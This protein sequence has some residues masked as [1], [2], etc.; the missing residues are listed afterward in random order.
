[1]CALLVQVKNNSRLRSLSR[2]ATWHRSGRCAAIITTTTTIN[3]TNFQDWIATKVIGA[4]S[5]RRCGKYSHCFC[6]RSCCLHFALKTNRKIMLFEASS[7]EKTRATYQALPLINVCIVCL[8]CCYAA[9]NYFK[10]KTDRTT[11][12]ALNRALSRLRLS[13]FPASPIRTRS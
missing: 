4:V 6:Q 12:L 2:R 13:D 1:M 10:N 11:K 5:M 9:V 7:K 8:G 3:G